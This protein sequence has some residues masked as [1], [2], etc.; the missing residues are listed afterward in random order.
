MS[1]KALAYA[2]GCAVVGVP[3]FEVIA[4]QADVTADRLDV[5]ADA[6]Q[7]KLYVQPFAR[8]TRTAPFTPAAAL[9]IVAGRQWANSRDPRTAVSGP[10]LRLAGAWLPPETP[11]ASADHREPTL[12]ALLAAGGPRWAAGQRD[13]LLRLEPIYLRPSSA[14]EQWNRRTESP[15]ISGRC[16]SPPS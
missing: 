8:H 6:Q 14:E 7:E 2:V 16:S 12:A 13:D 4:R 5:V 15:A 10:G 3:T 9:A 11:T 1:A